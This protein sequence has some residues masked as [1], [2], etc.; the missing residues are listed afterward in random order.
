M[1]PHFD[2]DVI[3]VGSGFGG[4]VAALRLSEKGYRVAV[5]EAGRHFERGDLPRSSWQ[6]RDYLWAPALGCFGIQRAH[7][8]R[9]AI[10]LAGAGVGGGSLN[11]ANT[12]YRPLDAFFEDP[13]WPAGTDWRRELEPYYLLAERMLGAVDNPLMSPADEAMRQV[14]EKMGV[15]GT[16]RLAPVGV[17]FGPPGTAPGASLA[18]PYFSGAGPVRRACLHCGECMTGCRHGAKNTLV[19]NYLYLAQGKGAAIAPMTTVDRLHPLAGGGW[20]VHSRPTGRWPWSARQGGATQLPREG[21]APG[22]TQA[23]AYVSPG[24][25]LRAQHVVLAAGAWGTQQLLHAMVAKGE[26]ARL[27]DHLGRLTRTNSESLLG[28]AVPL[29]RVKRDGTDFSRGVAITSSFYPGPGTHVEPVRY[30]RGSNLMGLFGALLVDPA[31]G[32][33][34]TGTRRLPWGVIARALAA[35]P[36]QALRA[37]DLRRWSERTVIALVMQSHNN[38]LQTKAKRGLTGRTRMVSAI[39]HGSA[40]PVRIPLGHQVAKR[41][42]QVIGGRPV[43]NWGELLGMP[44]TA[45]FLGGCVLGASPASGVVDAWHRVFGH[46]GLHIVDGSAVPANPGANPSL[47]ITAL[48]ERAFAYWPNLGDEDPRPPL[49]SGRPGAGM[50]SPPLRPIAPRSPAVPASS[51]AAWAV[52]QE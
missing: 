28:A 3:V 25:V 20:E 2:Y 52:P 4:S 24:R 46:A 1:A 5:L 10:V 48:A 34:S 27:S 44:I 6:V 12:L 38:S 16:F 29:D 19:E 7:F 42:A 39:G 33:L 8:L 14:A 11:Y 30:G 40:S 21:G 23:R 26:L 36:V 17:F 22:C 32:H 50:T 47:T 18:D 37:L 15:G 13:Q 43:G 35:H 49:G 45:H 31:P 41:L 51:Q 9:H